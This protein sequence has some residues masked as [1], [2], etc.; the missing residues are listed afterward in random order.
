MQLK[1]RLYGASVIFA[2]ILVSAP[3][4]EAGSKAKKPTK[5]EIQRARKAYNQGQK[6][7]D[8]GDYQEAKDAFQKAYDTVPNPVVLLSIAESQIHLKELDEAIAN[9][10]RYLE[11]RPGADDRAEVEK[12]IEEVKQTPAVLAIMSDPSGADISVDGIDTYKTTPAEIELAPGEHTVELS[13][14]GRE[15]RKETV[16]ARFGQRHE[17][18]I[19]FGEE[20][21]VEPVAAEPLADSADEA[22]DDTGEGSSIVPWI[23][24]VV[25][26]AALA[27]G[28][29]LGVLALDEEKNFNDDP[30]PTESMADSGERLALFADVSFGIG[31]AAVVT[32]FVLLFT[33]DDETPQEETLVSAK[34]DTSHINLSVTPLFSD[35]NALVSATL[36]F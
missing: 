5:A 14:S 20:L 7:F 25:G 36:S 4:V 27:T 10:E 17:L 12:R 34:R 29:V 1:R 32:G 31:I 35:K 8:S 19:E 26:V 9:L 2:L 3:S 15:S 33:L 23:V 13:L 11:E 24:M 22:S 16:F 21:P 6:A 30:N 28:T 18:Q